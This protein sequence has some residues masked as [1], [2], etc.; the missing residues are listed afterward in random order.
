MF[1]AGHPYQWT[2]E[3]KERE[4]RLF[5]YLKYQEVAYHLILNTGPNSPADLC[6]L[7]RR[8]TLEPDADDLGARCLDRS[9]CGGDFS[10]M[11]LAMSRLKKSRAECVEFFE[12]KLGW[13]Q[14]KKRR[15]KL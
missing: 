2:D 10:L 7:C 11:G 12:I 5:Q 14:P 4:D 3:W 15:R 13:V 1:P 8:V 9:G 6:P